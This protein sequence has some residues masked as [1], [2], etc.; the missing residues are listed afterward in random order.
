VSACDW[1]TR[2]A[3]AT[4]GAAV[5]AAAVAAAAAVKEGFYL[6]SP[7]V[8]APCPKG[9][10]KSGF[11]S[12]TNCIKCAVA[13]VSDGVTTLGDASTSVTDC[14]VLL[15]SFY[16]QTLAGTAPNLYITATKKCPQKFYCPGEEYASAAGKGV[17]TKAFDTLSPGLMVAE[18]TLVFPCPDDTFT[19]LFGASSGQACSKCTDHHK[20]HSQT[21]TASSR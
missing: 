7:G 19:E 3:A 9:E 4:N 6:Q 2:V 20:L 5:A 15:P 8:A 11:D 13:D 21:A 10:Y 1:P 12:V 17:P 18:E 16:A 14:K